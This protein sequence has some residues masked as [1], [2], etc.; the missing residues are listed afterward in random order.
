V[1]TG[2]WGE[3]EGVSGRN[4]LPK[5]ERRNWLFSIMLSVQKLCTYI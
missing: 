5:N 3:M 2:G 4:I 1:E